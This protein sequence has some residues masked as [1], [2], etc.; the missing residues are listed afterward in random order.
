MIKF[1]SFSDFDVFMIA[2]LT[3]FR[4]TL[5]VR[6]K[7]NYTGGRNLSTPNIKNHNTPDIDS[8]KESWNGNFSQPM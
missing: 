4:E 5:R 3:N 2:K 8:E 1:R 6:R 7:D